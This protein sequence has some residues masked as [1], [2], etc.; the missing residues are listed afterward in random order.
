M[1]EGELYEELLKIDA[2]LMIS[3]RNDPFKNDTP[4]IEIIGVGDTHQETIEQIMEI[5]Q[6]HKA[7]VKLSS[8]GVLQISFK[9]EEVVKD[10][11]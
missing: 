6:K 2:K 10:I 8:I 9:E 7:Y 11:A 1:K 4:K 3:L 5:T